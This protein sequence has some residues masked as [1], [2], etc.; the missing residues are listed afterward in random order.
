MSG[1]VLTWRKIK[2]VQM[3][4]ITVYARDGVESPQPFRHD[5][6]GDLDACKHGKSVFKHHTPFEVR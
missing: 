6:L 5:I 2:I 3:K 4:I 1:A